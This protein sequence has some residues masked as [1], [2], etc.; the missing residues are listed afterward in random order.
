[1]RFAAFLIAASSCVEAGVL[2]GIVIEHASGRGLA[3]TVV[4]LDAVPE[5]GGSASPPLLTRTGSAGQFA[6]PD[7][8]PGKYI[9]ASARTGFFP[10]AFGQRLPAGRGTPIAVGRDSTFFGELRMRRKGALTGRVLD[11]NGVGEPGVPVIAYRARLP[12]RSAGG[13]TSDDRGIFGIGSLEPGKYWVRSGGHTL[14]DKSGWV[15]TFGPRS[16]DVRNARLFSVTV[17]ADTG[18]ADVSPE[19]GSV[20]TVGGAITCAIAV[21]ATVSLS[22]ETLT[23]STQ[24]QCGPEPGGFQFQS[25]PAGLY[26]IFAASPDRTFSGF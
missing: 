24:T 22:S 15:P 17:D 5:P 23:R 26:E 7:V 4:R 2:Q 16:R 6:F 11:E 14:E 21:A 13:A 1:M 3:R 9:L 8:P 10:A 18:D 12:L 25:L 19:P 20:F